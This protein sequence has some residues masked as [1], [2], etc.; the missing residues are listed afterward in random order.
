MF[1][2]YVSFK[3]NRN[4]DNTGGG[5]V[6]VCRRSLDPMIYLLNISSNLGIECTSVAINDNSVLGKSF[7]IISLY[8]SPNNHLNKKNWQLFSTKF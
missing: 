1:N 2:D 6:I 8:R 4:S 7:V 3:R 5:T